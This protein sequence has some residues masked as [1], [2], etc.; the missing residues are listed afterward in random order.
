MSKARDRRPADARQ[1]PPTAGAAA[2]TRYVRRHLRLG[3]WSLLFFLTLGMALEAMHGF[4]VDWY[5][6]VANETRRLMWT[7][8]HAHGVLLALVHLAFASAI[9]V[10]DEPPQAR[11]QAAAS[12]CLTGASCLLPGGF[13]LGGVV[14]YGGDPGGGILLVPVGALL[15][16]TAVLLTAWRVSQRESG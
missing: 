10:L 2:P 16:L 4:K 7:L 14:I 3:W 8:A 9:R 11:W 13:L 5:L 1:A 15:L 6:N 12:Y